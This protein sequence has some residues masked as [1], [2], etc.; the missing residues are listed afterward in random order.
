MSK[1][2]CTQEVYNLGSWNVSD[3]FAGDTELECIDSSDIGMKNIE[4]IPLF[5]LIEQICSFSKLVDVVH[6]SWGIR[7]LESL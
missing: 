4:A 3:Q 2:V 7:S 5:F 6:D 1:V